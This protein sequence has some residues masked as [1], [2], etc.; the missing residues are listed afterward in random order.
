MWSNDWKKMPTLFNEEEDSLFK[1]LCW[2]T[3]YPF[4]NK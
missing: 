4:A 3:G 1:K 2:K